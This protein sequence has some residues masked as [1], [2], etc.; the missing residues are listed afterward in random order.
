MPGVYVNLSK[1]GASLS[2]GPRGATG[3]IGPGGVRG[4]L[5]IPGTGL[6]YTVRGSS[7]AK[8]TRGSDGSSPHG[9][10]G[11]RPDLG[12]LQRMTASAERRALVEALQAW[13]DGH[14]AEARRGFETLATSNGREPDGVD[15]AW[16]AA[17]MHLAA[18]DAK[19]AARFLD[20]VASDLD[21]LGT[22]VAALGV[23]PI[24][25]LEVTDLVTIHVPPKREA[26]HLAAAEVEERRGEH[27]RA[28]RHLDTL[29]SQDSSNPL[30]LA[31]WGDL[32][33][34]GPHEPADLH[35]VVSRMA[36]LQNDSVLHAIALLAKGRALTKLG[37]L[38]AAR[39]TFTMAYRKR[40]DRPVELRRTA[41]YE[42]ALTYE[43]LGN[44]S[45]ARS[46]LEALY[47]EDPAFED[48]AAR[49]GVAPS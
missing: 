35:D 39:D 46:E 6:F 49:L 20:V 4:T 37:L 42:R 33:V 32:I 26:Y 5:G 25:Q 28:R 2:L 47:A 45:R 30:W 9:V 31:S 10:Q 36:S 34:H 17:L 14:D 7:P 3:T 19:E 23:E 24:V 1:S 44:A 18:G 41:R 11:Q 22:A 13:H 16:F 27:A 48:V 29:L 38:T 15:A 21:A 43:A 8:R 12:F 40:K